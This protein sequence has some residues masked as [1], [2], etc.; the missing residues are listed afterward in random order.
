[1]SSKTDIKLKIV[2]II[3][4]A[5]TAMAAFWVGYQ[6]LSINRQLVEADFRPLLEAVNK[7]DEIRLYN[8]G[9]KVIN[10]EFI[11]LE[12]TDKPKLFTGYQHTIFPGDFV[13]LNVV[14]AIDQYL[15]RKDFFAPI[16]EIFFAIK[17]PSEIK[18]YQGLIPV[19]IVYDNNIITNVI[20]DGGKSG[21]SILQLKINNFS[22]LLSN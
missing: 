3:I 7:E 1:M 21:V 6:Q 20:I 15:N 10:L 11:R 9:S 8:R 13:V 14:E 16:Y 19:R 2:E 22:D 17:T 4:L 12:P 5:L 18:F